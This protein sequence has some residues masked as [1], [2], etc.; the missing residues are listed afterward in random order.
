MRT[1]IKKQTK[2]WL[3]IGCIAGLGGLTTAAAADTQIEVMDYEDGIT[4][5]WLVNGQDMQFPG[6]GNPGNAGGLPLA[7]FWGVTIRNEATT[8]SLVG[9]VSR[10]AGDLRVKVDI[11]VLVLNNFFNEPMDPAWFPLTLE[12]V[13]Y[14]DNGPVSV[15]YTT[16]GLAPTGTWGTFEFVIP[17]PTQ[18]ALPPGWGGTGDEDPVTFEPR[19]PASRTYASVLSAVDEV[20][21]TTM[22]PGYFYASSFWEVRVD[23]IE[24]SVIGGGPTCDSIDYNAD[25]LFPDTSDI[26]DFLSVFSGGP[27][28]TGTC[29]DIDFNNDGLFPDTLDID[30][31]LSVFSGGPCI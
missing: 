6:T 29:G 12:L 22:R 13:D 23:N 14:T 21:V 27:C 3:I 18:A 7:D 30:A 11:Q 19:L 10:H 28:S 24:V 16:S 8:C 26:D 4:N 31:L 1:Q 5:G 2:N 15:Y 17:N 9:D 25:G 20:R